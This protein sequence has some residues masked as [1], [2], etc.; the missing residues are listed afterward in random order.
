MRDHF[1]FYRS[2]YEAIREFEGDTQL[3]ILLN[4]IDYALNGVEPKNTGAA[5]AAFILMRPQIDANNKKYENGKKGGEHGK[6]GGRPI[7]KN[8]KETPK[9][10]QQNPKETPNVNVNVNDNDNVNEN[11]NENVNDI[12]PYNPPSQGKGECCEQDNRAKTSTKTPADL[13]FHKFWAAYPKKRS[14]GP[15][16]KA[17]DKIKPDRALLATMLEA[18]ERQ[19]QSKDWQKDKGQYIPYP[20]TWLNSQGWEDEM[21]VETH[22]GE[23]TAAD[24]KTKGYW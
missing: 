23:A 8:P 13:E 17:W 5:K 16:K 11:E 15:A 18:I 7:N 19:K 24:G 21:E 4:L 9:K 2:F 10:P 3:E 6:K 14:K 1:V 12:P 20:A 22:V